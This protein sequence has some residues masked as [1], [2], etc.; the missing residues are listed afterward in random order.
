MEK[1]RD[2]KASIGLPP[3]MRSMRAPGGISTSKAR[4]DAKK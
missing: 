3:R 4:R 2:R 1:V